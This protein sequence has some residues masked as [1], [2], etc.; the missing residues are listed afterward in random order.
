MSQTV[1][2]HDPVVERRDSGRCDGQTSN[3]VLPG[4]LEVIQTMELTNAQEGPRLSLWI[5]LSTLTM[6][7][8]MVLGAV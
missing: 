1:A 6:A 3:L 2:L 8:K 5:V 7:D 4:D